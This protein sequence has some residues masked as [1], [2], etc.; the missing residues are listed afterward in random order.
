MQITSTETKRHTPWGRADY[1]YK[2]LPGVAWVNTPGH[3]GFILSETA[4]KKYLSSAALARGDRFTKGYIAYEE[5]CAC[6]MVLLERPDFGLAIGL[7]PASD[8]EKVLLDSLRTYYPEYVT[9][10]G[11]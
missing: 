1:Q 7:V 3:G 5:D 10:R 9:E 11:L 6:Y 8:N 2:I 4:A